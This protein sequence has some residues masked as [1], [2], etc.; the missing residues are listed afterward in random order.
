MQGIVVTVVLERGFGFIR[1][2]DSKENVFFHCHDLAPLVDSRRGPEPT[3]CRRPRSAN[4]FAGVG[5]L[6]GSWFAG[7]ILHHAIV[8]TAVVA[9]MDLPQ[10][11][12]RERS[13][14]DP[15]STGSTRRCV[16]QPA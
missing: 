16:R 8:A 13:S 15:M 3:F 2:A 6:F 9:A 14:I 11:S 7:F 12:R 5:Y 10:S 4:L 1:P